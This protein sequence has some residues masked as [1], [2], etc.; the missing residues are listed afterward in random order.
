LIESVSPRI[1]FT[2]PQRGEV[3]LRS[4]SGE[5]A[6]TSP[7]GRGEFPMP[8]ESKAARRRPLNFNRC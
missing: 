7:D 1:R 6:P 5:G 4:K 3:D 8:L 2:S